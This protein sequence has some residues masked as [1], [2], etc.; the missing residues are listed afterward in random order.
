MN[1]RRRRHLRARRSTRPVHTPRKVHWCNWSSQPDIG[2]ACGRWTRPA[3]HQQ[4][5]AEPYLDDDGALY[6]FDDMLVTCSACLVLVEESLRKQADEQVEALQRRAAETLEERAKGDA[7]VARITGIVEGNN[8]GWREEHA[9]ELHRLAMTRTDEALAHQRAGRGAQA[10]VH[11]TLAMTLERQAADRATQEPT[12]S[13]LYRSAA[14]LARDAEQPD[15]MRRLVAC[16]LAGAPPAEIA[17][18][19]RELLETK[20]NEEHRT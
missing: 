4:S 8:P 5:K 13:V 19:L 7:F 1:P 12:R 18:E 11:F 20:D 17:D 14:T 9:Q 10:R 6:A 15:E 16:G 3:W 2:I